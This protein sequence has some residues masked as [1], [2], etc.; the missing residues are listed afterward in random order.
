MSLL[1]QIQ[2]LTAFMDRETYNHCCNVKTAAVSIAQYVGLDKFLLKNT[3]AVLD[4]GKL[5]I[6]EYIF[7]HNDP[8]SG[9]ERELMDLHSY[10]GYKKLLEH[11]VPDNIAELVLY[12]H[13][14][15][16]RVLEPVPKYQNW[17][18][19]YIDCIRTIDVYEAL[20]EERSFRCKY[21]AKEAVTIMQEEADE[22]YSQQ[23]MDLLYK[24]QL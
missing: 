8:L 22:H 18:E 24:L 13:G 12:H 14:E 9:I 21:T 2:E 15:A 11:E 19:P 16:V 1:P 10:L 3:C 6:N 4:I 20:T 23:I 5:L 17:M 7:T